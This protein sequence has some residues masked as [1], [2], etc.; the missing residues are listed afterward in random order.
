MEHIVTFGR[1]PH[2]DVHVDDEYVSN[3]HC[4]ISQDA[5][6]R[7]WVTDLGSTNGTWVTRPDGDG[8]KMRVRTSVQLYPG[9]K[10][11][12]GRT[13]LPWG[14]DTGENVA[15]G[16]N[17]RL[18]FDLARL[19]TDPDF[20]Q[21]LIGHGW[22]SGDTLVSCQATSTV[23]EVVARIE[24]RDRAGLVWLIY[25]DASQPHGMRLVRWEVAS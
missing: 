15:R 23:S 1:R 19:L 7:F 8:W 14:V 17:F 24:L 10:V 6:G 3:R 13:E 18:G 16:S 25:R 20:R 4:Q 12:I 5:A 21:W 2:A 22:R 11:T 9:D